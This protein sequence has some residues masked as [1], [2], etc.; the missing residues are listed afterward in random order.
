VRSA[1]WYCPLF[2]GEL[3]PA[4]PPLWKMILGPSEVPSLGTS[5]TLSLD[6]KGRAA[7]DLD[8][9]RRELAKD[10][11]ALANATGGA[12][13]VGAYEQGG[14]LGVIKPMDSGATARLGDAYQR[15]VRDLCAPAPIVNAVAIE[16]TPG[17]LLAVNVFAFP[18]GPVGVLCDPDARAYAF[19]LRVGTHTQWL[20]PEQLSMLMVPGVRRIAIML[21]AIPD[22]ER[23]VV[24]LTG[25]RGNNP[26]DSWTVEV[27]IDDLDVIRNRLCMTYGGGGGTKQ[28]IV[29]L[30]DIRAV[31]KSGDKWRLAIRGHIDPNGP[32]VSYNPRWD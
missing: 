23:K 6:F 16:W 14:R 32:I 7:I 12:I 22:G 21:D 8:D 2:A 28:L 25:P 13:L 11:A 5:E 29:P 4:M 18:A 1:A 24:S 9:D 30:D 17:F 27:S 20:R 31:W 10:V 19:P 15:A 3:T 26:S